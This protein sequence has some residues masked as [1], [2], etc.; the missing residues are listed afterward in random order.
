M[1]AKIETAMI[2]YIKGHFNSMADI[3]KLHIVIPSFLANCVYDITTL[4]S[5]GFVSFKTI[6]CIYNL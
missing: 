4:C 1:V 2:T 6:S 3:N 5:S